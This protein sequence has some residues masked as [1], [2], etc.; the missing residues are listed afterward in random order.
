MGLEVTVS[1]LESIGLL[2]TGQNRNHLNS[3]VDHE[4]DPDYVVVE[5]QELKLV[6]YRQERYALADYLEDQIYSIKK[7]LVLRSLVTIF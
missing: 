3:S 7:I 1:R 2:E 4:L 6:A 5:M